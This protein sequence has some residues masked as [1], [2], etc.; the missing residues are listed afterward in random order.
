MAL[1]RIERKE[2]NKM[3]PMKIVLGNKAQRKIILTNTTKLKK[4]SPECSKIIIVKDL[5]P[6]HGEEKKI[7][8]KR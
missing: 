1:Y 3:R 2:D 8:R 7:K 4:V 6:T 5:S